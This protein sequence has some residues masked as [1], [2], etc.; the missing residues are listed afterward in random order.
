MSETTEA[1]TPETSGEAVE[2]TIEP[3]A[4]EP[5][6]STE[7]ERSEAG[8][9]AQPVEEEPKREKSERAQER[10]QQFARRAK[11]AEERAEY[12]EKLYQNVQTPPQPP[13]KPES[14]QGSEGESEF[15]TADD[16]A[17]KTAQAVQGSIRAERAQEER[18]RA[19]EALK[20]DALETIA[21]YPELEEDDELG[22]MVFD[23]AK[24]NGIS[25]KAAAARVKERLRTQSEQAEK[26]VVADQITR[27]GVSSPQGQ[28]VSSGEPTRPDLNSMDESQK[29]ANWSEI[30]ASYRK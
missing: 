5:K 30:I 15:V 12:W 29:A 11:N 6:T 16:V 14:P 21:A 7:A 17:T 27:S 28:G 13:V 24:S 26:R 2:K 8:T 25:L 18:Q 3:S 22:A 23:F 9:S 10:I 4:S 19:A 20:Q 1:I